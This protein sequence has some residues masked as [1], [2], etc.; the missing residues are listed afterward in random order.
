MKESFF[1]CFLRKID[2]IKKSQTIPPNAISVTWDVK[3]LYTSI[4][5]KEGLDALQKTQENEN[6]PEKKD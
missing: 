3:S 4:P 6:V 2:E 5:H 1:A